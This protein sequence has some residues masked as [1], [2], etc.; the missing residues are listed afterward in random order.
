MGWIAPTVKALRWWPLG[1]A[2]AAALAFVLAVRAATPVPLAA[3]TITLVLAAVIAPA[4]AGIADPAD[5]MLR[6]LPIGAPRRLAHRVGLMAMP[7][8]G[9]VALVTAAFGARWPSPHPATLVALAA[10]GITAS[11]V[12]MRRRGP[13]AGEL[14]GL[15]PVA[16]AALRVLLAQLS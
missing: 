16:A 15:V 7:A 4:I 3:P 9:C 10:A 11:A 1:A 14:A 2:T 12:L 5:E 8:A 6:A 13:A